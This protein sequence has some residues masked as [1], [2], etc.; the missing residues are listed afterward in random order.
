MHTRIRTEKPVFSLNRAFSQ[1]LFEPLASQS[2]YSFK[3]EQ[4]KSC[5]NEHYVL[6]DGAK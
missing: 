4:Q 6:A 2:A 3:D 1:A 5:D